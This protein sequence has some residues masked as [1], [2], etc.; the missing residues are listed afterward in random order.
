VIDPSRWP[1]LAEPRGSA[2]RAGIARLLFGSAATRLRIRVRLP[3]GRLLGAGGPEAP[4]MTG[5]ARAA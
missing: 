5:W 1:D 4:L 3:D 2:S